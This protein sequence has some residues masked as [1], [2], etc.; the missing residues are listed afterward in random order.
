MSTGAPSQHMSQAAASTQE[1]S[2]KASE[3][4]SSL[5]EAA[6]HAMK[7][8]VSACAHSGHMVKDAAGN[9][10]HECNNLCRHG[11][12]C[13]KNVLPKEMKTWIQRHP[14][15][16]TLLF[17]TLSLMTG[18]LLSAMGIGG[19]MAGMGLFSS[20]RHDTFSY[21]KGSMESQAHMTL[22]RM[23]QSKQQPSMLGRMMPST[24]DLTH[25]LQQMTAGGGKQQ[26]QY[27]T[28]DLQKIIQQA[29][30]GE[31][32]PS[33]L[34]EKMPSL[35]SL[36]PGHKQVQ[37]SWSEMM[38]GGGGGQ[39]LSQ[40][41]QQQQQQPSGGMFSNLFGGKSHQESEQEQLKRLLHEASRK[42]EMTL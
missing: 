17:L 37:P 2:R 7:A 1:A 23:I 16:T 11:A 33:S 13:A 27:S 40:Q 32:H 5:S 42:A 21:P 22:D 15:M 24:T 29:M 20:F 41:H 8:C 30:S 31:A 18:M 4:T 34:Y 36:L 26:Q 9:L 25:Y 38:S 12:E 6:S 3:S 14:W 28:Q 10:I 39:W 35:S 19:A